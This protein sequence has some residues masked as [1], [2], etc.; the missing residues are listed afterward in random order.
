MSDKEFVPC[1][2]VEL[3]YHPVYMGDWDEFIYP[4]VEELHRTHNVRWPEMYA[5]EFED[6]KGDY[7]EDAFGYICCDGDVPVGLV[8]GWM[9]KK[10]RTTPAGYIGD[11]IVLNKH[12]NLGIATHLLELMERACKERGATALELYTCAANTAIEFYKSQGMQTVKLG[13]RKELD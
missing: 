5:E 1:H 2:N 12:R 11:L 3:T 9:K 13:L 7:P 6:V 8:F 4:L 10:N